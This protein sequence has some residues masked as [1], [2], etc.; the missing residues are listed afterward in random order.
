MPDS[1]DIVDLK[2]QAEIVGLIVL[3]DA[4]CAKEAN[5]QHVE[6]MGTV[7]W[8]RNQEEVISC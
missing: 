4:L 7:G 2:I 5:V 3:C 6:D 8:L 1:N